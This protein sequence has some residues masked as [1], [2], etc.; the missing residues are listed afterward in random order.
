MRVAGI[1]WVAALVAAIAIY[2]VGALIYGFIVDPQI[3]M[4]GAR[5]TEAELEAVGPARIP[6]GMVMPLA[7]AFGMAIVFKWA[8]VE[9]LANGVKWGVLIA[10]LSAIPAL[11]YGWV[12]G[13][14]PASATMLD[15]VHLLLSHA[16]AGAILAAWK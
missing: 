9:G 12:Y 5:I 11:W 14:G 1:N 7:T 3:W 10:F 16:I 2:A 8:N 4:E 13:I 15:S 6:F